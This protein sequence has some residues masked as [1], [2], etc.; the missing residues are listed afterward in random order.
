VAATETTQR[1]FFLLRHL[2]IST[3]LVAKE[4]DEV[5]AAPAPFDQSSAR[6]W[7]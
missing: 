4:L 1:G 6:G 5:D 7:A 2:E 3:A